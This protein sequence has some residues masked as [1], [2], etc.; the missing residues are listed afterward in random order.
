M[1]LDNP[2][3]CRDLF[4]QR[5]SIINGKWHGRNP[6]H[7]YRAEKRI[8]LNVTF[9]FILGSKDMQRTLN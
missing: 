7:Q 4:I 8:T 2:C 1:L 3:L 6:C 9:T 5:S